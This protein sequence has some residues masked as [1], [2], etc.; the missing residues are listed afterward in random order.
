M[1]IPSTISREF[2]MFHATSVLALE[3]QLRCQEKTTRRFFAPVSSFP[4]RVEKDEPR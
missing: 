3:R 4:A 1:Q 2:Q